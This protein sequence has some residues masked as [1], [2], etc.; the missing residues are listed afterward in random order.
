MAASG[1][2]S[3]E[4]RRPFPLDGSAPRVIRHSNLPSSA[5]TSWATTV[6]TEAAETHMEEGSPKDLTITE[7]ESASELEEPLTL[8]ELE[9][10]WEL[11]EHPTI[12]E[13][14]AAAALE[15]H[16]SGPTQELLPSPRA[17]A[18]A[19]MSTSC[20]RTW[21]PSSRGRPGLLCWRHK[22]VETA[23]RSPTPPDPAMPRHPREIL[24]VTR[25]LDSLSY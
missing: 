7:L 20:S 16:S 13:R 21:P 5:G 10:A 8:T 22:A 25:L 14:E 18:T 11:E 15:E 17:N 3:P 19:F 4:S 2:N 24:L 6:A 12:E 1:P 23:P 9:A